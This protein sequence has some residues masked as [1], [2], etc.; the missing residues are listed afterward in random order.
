MN[1]NWDEDDITNADNHHR[2]THSIS[3]IVGD[4]FKAQNKDTTINDKITYHNNN[5][6]GHNSIGVK[7]QP[8]TSATTIMSSNSIRNA[9]THG[10]KTIEA[11]RNWLQEDFDEN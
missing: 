2:H 9:I 6:N 11:D 4:T 8:L 3:N 5:H 10:V 1:D 7:K